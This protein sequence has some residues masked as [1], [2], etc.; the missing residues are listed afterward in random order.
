MQATHTTAEG[1]VRCLALIVSEKH[2]I[3][4][5]GRGSGIAGHKKDATC[6]EKGT[7]EQK[8]LEAEEPEHQSTGGCAIF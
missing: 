6:Q 1:K 4:K 5:R 8:A 3:M 7:A 2:R